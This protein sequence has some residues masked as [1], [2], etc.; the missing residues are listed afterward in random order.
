MLTSAVL[1]R[2]RRER[3]WRYEF[4][5]AMERKGKKQPL[6]HTSYPA[7][8]WTIDSR[9]LFLLICL[10]FLT[11]MGWNEKTK[12]VMITC[13]CI[14]SIQSTDRQ[15]WKWESPLHL[16]WHPESLW[17]PV[18]R[19]KERDWC[20]QQRREWSELGPEKK[21]WNTVSSLIDTLHASNTNFQNGFDR[22]GGI[23]F[24]PNL[25]RLLQRIHSRLR[26]F[27]RID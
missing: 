27:T 1:V 17:F 10:L 13:N 8:P 21:L 23:V 9:Q 25:A 12:W 11:V 16:R 3:Q 14:I 19:R 18:H 7:I 24:A 22:V 15:E 26:Y 4:K 20:I 2:E 5:G 6:F